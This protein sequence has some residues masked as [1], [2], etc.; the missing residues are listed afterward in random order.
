MCQSPSSPRSQH[1]DPIAQIAA[2][3]L[4][5]RAAA[6]GSVVASNSTE[7]RGRKGRAAGADRGARRVITNDNNTLAKPG[8]LYN[9]QNRHEGR[10]PGTTWTATAY[11]CR[12]TPN[13]TF[14]PGP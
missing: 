10:G 1:V 8:S 4:W 12:Y 13:A 14:A 9:T 3:G 11:R 2:E 5:C 7:S 6:S